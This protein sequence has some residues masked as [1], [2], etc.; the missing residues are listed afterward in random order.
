MKS[1]TKILSCLGALAAAL[2]VLALWYE[3]LHPEPE[4]TPQTAVA[5]AATTALE[6]IATEQPEPASA[7]EVV[8]TPDLVLTEDVADEVAATRRMYM[9]HQP[10][11]A[12]DI[13]DPRSEENRRILET[14]VNKALIRSAANPADSPDAV[15]N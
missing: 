7:E 12:P 10:L 6:T 9:A 15:N 4:G 14:M 5:G 13:A 2:I 3:T 8:A 11:R 1:R